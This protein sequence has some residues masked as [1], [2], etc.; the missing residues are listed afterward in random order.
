MGSLGRR[1]L[2]SCALSVSCVEAKKETLFLEVESWGG[3]R[4]HA[5]Q[6]GA[7]MPSKVETS[8]KEHI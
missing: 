1:W 5:Q 7:D 3:R 2:G 4:K 6:F 8:R